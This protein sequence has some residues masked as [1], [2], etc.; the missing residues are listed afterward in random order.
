[1]ICKCCDF[2][3]LCD[4]CD[5]EL[6]PYLGLDARYPVWDCTCGAE[7]IDYIEAHVRALT[8]DISEKIIERMANTRLIPWHGKVTVSEARRELPGVTITAEQVGTARYG[9]GP[10]VVLRKLGET[11]QDLR[12][13][14]NAKYIV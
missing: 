5:A 6:S 4:S 2:K 9:V 12:D 3:F 14:L 7:S 10:I 8:R 11:D 13:R 1:M